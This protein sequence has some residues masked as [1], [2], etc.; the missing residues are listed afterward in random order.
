MYMT[1]YRV[2]LTNLHPLERIFTLEYWIDDGW[3]VG[4]LKEVPDV[5]SQGANLQEPE[6]NIEDAFKM[7]IVEKEEY[8]PS[9]EVKHKELSFQLRREIS[10]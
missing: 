6:E 5:F 7:M 4:R 3:Y 9:V 2:F 10:L 1:A 8:I